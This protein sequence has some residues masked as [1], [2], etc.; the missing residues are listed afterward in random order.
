MAKRGPANRYRIAQC[1]G[2]E[3]RKIKNYKDV[4]ELKANINKY[5]N[6]TSNPFLLGDID[7]DLRT[8]IFT[9]RKF[10]KISEATTLEAIDKS[11]VNFKSSFE[12]KRIYNSDMQNNHPFVIIYRA[13][14]TIKL[15]PI[16]Y[17]KNKK[18]LDKR[19]VFEE[20]IELGRDINFV[21]KLINSQAIRTSSRTSIEDYDNLYI[22][23]DV[24]KHE[25]PAA[26]NLSPMHKF[27]KS[28]TYEGGKFNYFNY[29]LL[30]MLVKEQQELYEEE[31]KN[32]LEELEEK[33]QAQES[34]EPILG[35][36]ILPEF[37]N[38]VLK[39]TYEELKLGLIE[40][41]LEEAYQKKLIPRHKTTK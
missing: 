16:I 38:M 36:M 40:G 41:T 8:S 39:D 37:A 25:L 28:F 15:L 4:E 13:A 32:K 26:V 29:R 11:T 34:I 31:Q 6:K 5:N 24:L 22:L 9:F 35:Q 14:K 19:Y 2:I 18:Y 33:E 1:E 10:K 3:T 21:S 30:A 17:E 7:Y 12:L 20:F 27:F 23:R